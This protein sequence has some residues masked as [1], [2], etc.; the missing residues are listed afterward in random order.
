MLKGKCPNCRRV[1]FGWALHNKKEQICPECN[2]ELE[3]T[4][5]DQSRAKPTFLYND[6]SSGRP[7]EKRN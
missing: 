2:V 6:L 5:G 1:Y 7:G 4:E 3:I